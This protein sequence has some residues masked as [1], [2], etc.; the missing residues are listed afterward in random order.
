[1]SAEMS[2]FAAAFNHGLDRGVGMYEKD[3]QQAIEHE[4]NK[5]LRD[6]HEAT[7]RNADRR[8]DIYAESV[9]SA[10]ETNRM[11]AQAALNK[12]AGKGGGGAC[13][14]A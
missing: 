3:Q 13:C 6:Q 4:K 1:M 11:K 14:C 8:T 5:V 10:A 9:K 7:A 2:D 12:S